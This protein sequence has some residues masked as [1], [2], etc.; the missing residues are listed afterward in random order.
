VFVGGGYFHGA[1]EGCQAVVHGVR[2]PSD[3]QARI[4]LRVARIPVG[5]ESK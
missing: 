5:K 1:H 4:G 3:R 2:P